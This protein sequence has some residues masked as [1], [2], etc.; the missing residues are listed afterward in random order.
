MLSTSCRTHT[1]AFILKH[2]CC[3]IHLAAISVQ[4][5]YSSNL[6]VKQLG[7]MDPN[8]AKCLKS[9]QNFSRSGQKRI[10]S[11]ASW[12]VHPSL[13]SFWPAH[14]LCDSPW[15][16]QWLGYCLTWLAHWTRTRDSY[17]ARTHCPTCCDIHSIRTLL[18]AGWPLHLGRHWPAFYLCYSS[19]AGQWLGYFMT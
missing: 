13:G 19:W 16:G 2:L 14:Y 18:Q 3:S 7:K 10:Y 8:W 15:A 9:G 4:H 11:W 17:T 6:T 1:K 12:P 5:S